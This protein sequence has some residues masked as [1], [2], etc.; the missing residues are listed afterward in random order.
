MKDLMNR[1]LLAYRPLYLRGL[2]MDG[3]YRLPPPQTAPPAKGKRLIHLTPVFQ[4]ARRRV[5]VATAAAAAGM[6]L[7]TH[8]DTCAKPAD[9]PDVC[10]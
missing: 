6:V 8:E 5:L 10:V 1:V 9:A 4:P 3:Q 2:L 7:S